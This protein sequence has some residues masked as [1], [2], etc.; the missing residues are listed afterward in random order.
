[1]MM[2]T[3]GL[4]LGQTMEHATALAS[5]I[6]PESHCKETQL[7][8][9]ASAFG[10]PTCRFLPHRGCQSD[11]LRDLGRQRSTPEWEESL[12]CLLMPFGVGDT[13]RQKLQLLWHFMAQVS[14]TRTAR[15]KHI[16]IQVLV[17]VD[18]GTVVLFRELVA[19]KGGGGGKKHLQLLFFKKQCLLLF[20]WLLLKAANLS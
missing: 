5:Q 15:E 10:G 18:E 3:N 2:E 9:R 16:S 7:R 14:L 12:L 1:M 19:G 4:L 6:D 11:P 17:S 8:S 13:L 20:P